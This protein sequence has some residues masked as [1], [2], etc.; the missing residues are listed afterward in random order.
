MHSGSQPAQVV[1]AVADF[2]FKLPE[3]FR[4][5]HEESQYVV[6]LQTPT[7]EALEELQESALA[8]GMTPISLREPDRAHELTAMAFVPHE[9]NSR[10]LSHLPLAGKHLRSLTH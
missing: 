10:F 3:A 6:V 2:A 7:S 9:D 8:K 5:G 4:R 1:H